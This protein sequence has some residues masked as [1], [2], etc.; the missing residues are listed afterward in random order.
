MVV[1]DEYLKRIRA[2][3]LSQSG[4]RDKNYERRVFPYNESHSSYQAIGMFNL[5]IDLL[6]LGTLLS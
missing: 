2:K 4:G 3:S 6:G 5:R 1:H